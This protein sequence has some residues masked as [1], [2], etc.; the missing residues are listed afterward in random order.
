MKY[1]G[2]V[3]TRA[4]G[5]TALGGLCRRSLRTSN[6]RSD[7]AIRVR[8]LDCAYAGWSAWMGSPESRRSGTLTIA[9]IQPEGSS[10]YEHLNGSGWH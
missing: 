9:K 7:N 3:R 6:R 2:F 4:G 8:A 1:R 10:I 5:I